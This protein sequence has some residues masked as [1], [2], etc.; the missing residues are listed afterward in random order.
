MVRRLRRHANITESTYTHID[1]V[2]HYSPG[3]HGAN[4]VG[5]PSYMQSVVG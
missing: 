2:A 3:L 4:L 1:G 5:V